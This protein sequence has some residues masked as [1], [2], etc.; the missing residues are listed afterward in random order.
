MNTD[1]PGHQTPSPMQVV[2]VGMRK[3]KKKRMECHRCQHRKVI[4]SGRYARTPF[5]RTPCAK[6]ELRELSPRTVA[7][8]PDRPAYVTGKD[9]PGEPT[10]EMVTFAEEE[11]T[12]E[13]MLPVGVMEELVARL[14]N[15]PQEVRDVVCLRF[16]GMDYKDIGRRQ[17]ITAAGAEARHERAMRLF[18][19]LRELFV[20][21]TARHRM[22]QPP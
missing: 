11:E 13:A 9:C 21:K 1:T 19:E 16:A 3:R 6:C 20:L 5:R 15:L 8:D 22:R 4:D 18:P 17:R 7:V 14:L 10:C 12:D 2:N